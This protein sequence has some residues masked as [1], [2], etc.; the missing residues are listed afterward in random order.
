M[1]QTGVKVGEAREPQNGRVAVPV[2]VETRVFGDLRGTISFP[3]ERT[4]ESARVAAVR[5]ANRRGR[6]RSVT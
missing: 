2:V 4:G 1:T 5:R 3:V 6:V